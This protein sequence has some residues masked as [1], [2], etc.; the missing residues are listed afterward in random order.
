MATF[1]VRFSGAGA[2][3]Y[4]V[5]ILEFEDNPFM[6]GCSASLVCQTLY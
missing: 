5:H 2:M 1:N 4:R 3:T 6:V